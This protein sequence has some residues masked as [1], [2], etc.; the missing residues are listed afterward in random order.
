MHIELVVN[1]CRTKL[2]C[3]VGAADLRSE[4]ACFISRIVHCILCSCSLM[5]CSMYL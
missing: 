5:V 4:K 1:W 2:S 3:V